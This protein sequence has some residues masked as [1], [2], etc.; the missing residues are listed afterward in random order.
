MHCSHDHWLESAWPK[1]LQSAPSDPFVLIQGPVSEHLP[2][3]AGRDEYAAQLIYNF[4]RAP[5]GIQHAC[6]KV[7]GNS[8]HRRLHLQ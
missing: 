1:I 7:L 6:W 5:D 2:R 4:C 8:P 3:E